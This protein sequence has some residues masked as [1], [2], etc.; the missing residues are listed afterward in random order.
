MSPQQRIALAGYSAAPYDGPKTQ[1]NFFPGPENISE[2]L[3]QGS[4]PF[5][6]AHLA[7]GVL[8]AHKG[9]FTDNGMFGG[10][11]VPGRGHRNTLMLGF[12]REIGIGVSAGT[13]V[14]QP[15]TTWDSL[16]IVEDFGTQTSNTPFVTGVVYQDTNGNG[17]Y[18]PGEGI[19]GIRVDVTGSNF[20]A[21]TSPSGG[22]SV[23]VGNGSFTVT[24]SGGSLTTTQKPVTVANSLNAKVDLVAPAATA[25]TVLANVSSRLPVGTGDD[26]LFAGFIITGTQPKKV[27]IRAIG[28]SLGLAGQL[29]NPTL[30]LFSGQTSLGTNDDWKNQPP[31]DK[32]A[33]ETSIPPTHDRE[34]ALVRTLPANGA[35]YTAVVRGVNNTTGIGVVEVYDLDDTSNP[36]IS[37]LANVSSRGVV[38]TGNNILI[39]GT[40]VFG[41]TSEKVVIRAI[42]PSLNI[43]GKLPN[44]KLELRDSNGALV[45]ENDN[46]RTGGQEVEIAALG[47]A[48]SNDLESVIVATISGNRSSYTAIV[49]DVNNSTGIAV[50]EVYALN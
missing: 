15:N 1:N 41:Q 31:A 3:S 2:A 36:A 48:P 35:G 33:V 24:F 22:Y 23:P 13:D 40:I 44:P 6:G 4:G 42:G 45:Q 19:G 46:W 18:D 7:A 17:F 32:Q 30:E 49:R 5:I 14:Q 25:P 21:I 11:A 29:E 8:A 39:A 37:K 43:A 27:I 47:F 28:P 20:F 26:A 9:L 10:N 12:F 50:V 16:Y 34:S 38:Q